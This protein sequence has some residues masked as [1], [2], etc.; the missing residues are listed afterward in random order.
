MPDASV[1]YVLRVDKWIFNMGGV[2][3]DP[4]TCSTAYLLTGSTTVNIISL[5]H[6]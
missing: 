5:D 4:T 3:V 2:N 1:A 6:E